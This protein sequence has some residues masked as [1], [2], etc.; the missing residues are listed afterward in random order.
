[1]QCQ[2]VSVARATCL[3]RSVVG[4]CRS[5]CRARM[6]SGIRARSR[7]TP[8]AL[9]PRMVCVAEGVPGISVCCSDGTLPHVHGLLTGGPRQAQR[10]PG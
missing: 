2:R 4:Y 8:V 1:M 10:C 3:H 6:R 5:R 9:A 7:A